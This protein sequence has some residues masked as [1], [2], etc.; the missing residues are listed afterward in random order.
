MTVLLGLG[1]VLMTGCG[2]GSSTQGNAT[3]LPVVKDLSGIKAEGRLEPIRFAKLALNADGQV[4]EV[5]AKQGDPVEAGQLIASLDSDQT[6]TLEGARASASLELATAYQAVRVAQAKLDDYPMPR[7][8]VGLTAAQAA[9]LWLEKLDTARLEFEPYKGTSRKTLKPNHVFPSLPRRVWF[10]TGEYDGMAKEYKKAVDV[11][12]MN[13]TKAIQ[14]LTL[15]AALQS[16][17]AKLAQAQKNNDSLQDAS[18]SD[19]TAGTRAALANAEVRAPFSGTITNLDLKVGEFVSAGSPVMTIADFSYWV[20]KTTDLTEIDVVNIAENEPVT[21]A[22][23]SIPDASF[24]G[25]ILS[26][27]Q[28]YSERQGDIVY[29]VTILLADKHPAMRWGMTAQV[30]FG[31]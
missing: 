7:I 19:A 25:R 8:F 15:D 21:V 23:D 5:R 29:A 3:P 11:A 20:V 9:R 14:W 16:A 30:T 24:E 28:N 12:W 26:I 22:L 2:S 10:D 18:L 13:Y 6:Q 27:G 31:E 17:K 4:S 1:L